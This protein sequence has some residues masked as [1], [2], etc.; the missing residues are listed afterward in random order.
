MLNDIYRVDGRYPDPHEIE[1]R[2][3]VL[4]KSPNS[5]V[6]YDAALKEIREAGLDQHPLLRRFSV[7]S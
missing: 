7:E 3:D 4:K 2:L 6:A 1:N 5:V